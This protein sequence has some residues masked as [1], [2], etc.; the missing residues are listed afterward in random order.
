MQSDEKRSL[1]EAPSKRKARIS[2]LLSCLFMG[3]GQLYNRQIVKGLLYAAL[4]LFVLIFLTKPIIRGLWGLITLGE[5]VQVRRRGRIIEQ[6]DHSIFLM[7]TGIIFLLV[8][9][10]FVA[11]YIQ[12]IRDAYRN[13][14]LR[15]AGKP[16]HTFKQS[17]AYAWDKGFA[18]FLLTPAVL[19]TLFLTV[20]PLVFGVLIAFTN[21][22]APNHLPPKH[23]VDWVGLQTFFDLFRLDAWKQTFFGVATWTVI[24]AIIATA[25]TCF[26]GLFYALIINYH[27]V[28]FKRMWRTI[29]ILAW[30][31]PQF[32]AVLI[33]RN[34]FN[35]EFG[36]LNQY[37]QALGLEAIPWLSDP[38]WAKVAL[39]VVNI[40]FGFP[41]WM[42][43]M[44]GVLTGIDKHLYEAA[45]VDGATRFQQFK[46]IT[47]PLVTFATAPLLIMSFAMNFNNFNVIYLFTE[48]GP[49]NVD[50]SYAGSTDILISW[51][52]KL[53]LDQGQYN[54]AA[55][56]SIIIF[57]VIAGFSIWN[58]RNTRAF[59]EE[60]MIQ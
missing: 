28:C 27:R 14:Q 58:F 44:S 49:A 18:Y 31:V 23:L 21:Y 55:V 36:P 45:Q 20:L 9:I 51:I 8:L 53:T 29:I 1:T 52:Y 17:L 39:V 7:I 33:F 56:V 59:K 22:S 50:Y 40:W 16:V 42:A 6:G 4:E 32:V 30:A 24:W 26:V 46:S 10:L 13:G 54:M 19:F 41:Y 60:D 34:I 2:A 12:N 48:G 5:E 43:L 47:L 11:A 35:G 3:F 37:L 15:D 25:T 57:I 38:F